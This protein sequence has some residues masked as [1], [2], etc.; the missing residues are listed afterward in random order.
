MWWNSLFA[1]GYASV[2]IDDDALDFIFDE[3]GGCIDPDNIEDDQPFSVCVQR[4]VSN[5][6]HTEAVKTRNAISEII[7]GLNSIE[8]GSR[9]LHDSVVLS[10]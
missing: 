8:W 5:I 9:D 2:G 6:Y 3:T 4:I 10:F 7:F 1:V